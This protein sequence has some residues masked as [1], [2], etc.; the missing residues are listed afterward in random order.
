MNSQR[1]DKFWDK[2]LWDPHSPDKNSN[3]V[4][5]HDKVHRLEHKNK[6]AVQ[7]VTVS[8]FGYRRHNQK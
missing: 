2:R 1:H 8:S 3:S 6:D 5:L 7:V 4:I